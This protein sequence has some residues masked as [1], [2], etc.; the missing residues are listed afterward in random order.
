LI[1]PALRILA[2]GKWIMQ[3]ATN[4]MPILQNDPTIFCLH[5]GKFAH[6]VS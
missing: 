2:T 3:R 1:H 4:A 5:N 6:V